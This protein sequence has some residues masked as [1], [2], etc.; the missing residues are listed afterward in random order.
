[1]PGGSDSKAPTRSK[2]GKA[3]GVPKLKNQ[4]LL[5]LSTLAMAET[6]R[7]GC[8]NYGPFLVPYYNTAP[9]I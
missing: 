3:S 5:T 7:G 9:N 4:P 6:D 1:M 8:Q 2:L